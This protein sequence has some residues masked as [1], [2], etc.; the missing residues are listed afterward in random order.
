MLGLG[1]AQ[2][3]N[4]QNCDRRPDDRVAGSNLLDTKALSQQ[5]VYYQGIG[6][7]RGH[8]IIE[9]LLE[10]VDSI[11]SRLGLEDSEE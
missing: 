11:V 2:P 3:N 9:A 6:V 4:C 5:R 10:L 7:G 1:V 8:D